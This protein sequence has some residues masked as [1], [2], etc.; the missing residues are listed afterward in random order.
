[1][2]SSRIRTIRS[3]SHVYPSMHALDTGVSARESVYPSIQW[4]RHTP[5]EQNG[6]QV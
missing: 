5:C 2:H 6:R 1:M 4:G 3:S